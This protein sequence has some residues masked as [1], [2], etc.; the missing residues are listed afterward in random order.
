MGLQLLSLVNWESIVC[1]NANKGVIIINKNLFDMEYSTQYRK[2]VDYLKS[3]G[4]KYSFVKR[5][6]GI[7]TYKYTKSRELFL[8]LSTFY[9]EK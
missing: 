6:N 8:A 4:I 3:K 5:I 1:L 2:E 7:P 9:L